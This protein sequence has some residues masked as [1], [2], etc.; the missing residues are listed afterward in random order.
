[1]LP[2]LLFVGAF[3]SLFDGTH[4]FVAGGALRPQIGPKT[5]CRSTYQHDLPWEKLAIPFSCDNW[6]LCGVRQGEESSDGAEY[7]VRD[8]PTLTSTGLPLI[9]DKEPG[10]LDE[11]LTHAKHL[12]AVIEKD[13]SKYSMMKV[14]WF[15]LFFH[16]SNVVQTL[17]KYLNGVVI[18]VVSDEPYNTTTTAL[19]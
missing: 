1:M 10:L 14:S 12:F 16:P 2:L 4:P 13:A 18:C 3:C 8:V 5:T 6:A 7:A 15:D 17:F 11:I 9:A 19:L